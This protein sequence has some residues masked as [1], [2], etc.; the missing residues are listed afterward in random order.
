MATAYPLAGKD[1]SVTGASTAAKIRSWEGT[2]ELDLHEVTNFDSNGWKEF[3]RGLRGMTGTIR[4][5]GDPPAI[6]GTGASS[7][8]LK[9]GTGGYMISGSAL[10]SNFRFNVDIGAEIGHEFDYTFNGEAT[11]AESS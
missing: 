8:A 10:L 5:V 1:G 11:I 6:D 4:C 7:I 3:V 9:E 2:I